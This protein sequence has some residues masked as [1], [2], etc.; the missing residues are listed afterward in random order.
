MPPEFVAIATARTARINAAWA[1]IRR[2]RGIA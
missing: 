2:E 1:L